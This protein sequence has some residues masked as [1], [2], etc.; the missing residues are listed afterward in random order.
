MKRPIVFDGEM[1]ERIAFGGKIWR[2]EEAT[3]WV[4]NLP[5]INVEKVTYWQNGSEWVPEEE[6]QKRKKEKKAQAL[7]KKAM[8]VELTVLMKKE[9]E[10]GKKVEALQKK[11]NR[12]CVI[13]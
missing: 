12:C 11:V 4:K 8:S 9:E 2:T 13:L 3:L 7:N 6:Q 10:E 5:Y 1:K